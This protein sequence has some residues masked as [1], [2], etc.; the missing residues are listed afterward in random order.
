VSLDALVVAAHPDDAEM[1][2]GGT[3]LLWRDA[4]LRVGVVDLT[5]GER[6]SRGSAETRAREAEAA[7]GLLQLHRRENLGLPDARLE[8]TLEAREALARRIR[9]LRPRLLL[10]HHPD[11]PHPDHQAA[12]QLGR[13]SWF[14]SGLSRLV[15]DPLDPGR[16][17]VRRPERVYHFPVNRHVE[18]TFV[19][20]VSDV[21]EEKLELVAC[22]RSQLGPGPP[23]GLAPLDRIRA[24]G[25]YWGARIGVAHGEPL[26]HDG[27][28]PFAEP[29]IEAGPKTA[30]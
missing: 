24:A 22:Y 7:T 3:L 28:L 17:E 16:T 20:D 27:P 10:L 25:R 9:A 14:L 12:A 4:G 5:R 6:G 18:P 21:W 26:V 11:D 29:L 15:D 8:A 19:V 2:L 13:A 23:G 1:A 30:H